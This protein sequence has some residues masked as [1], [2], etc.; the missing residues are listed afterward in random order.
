VDSCTAIV[1]HLDGHMELVRH[2]MVQTG[3]GEHADELADA[4][5]G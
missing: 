2:G 4:V 5:A 1:E 3:T